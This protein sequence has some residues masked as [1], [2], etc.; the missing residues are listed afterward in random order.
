MKKSRRIFSVFP[1]PIFLFV[2]FVFVT[3]TSSS[4]EL[5]LEGGAGNISFDP[6]R[7][8]P[9]GGERFAPR[10]YPLALVSVSG[11]FN[12]TISYE[13]AWERDPV[14]RNRVTAGLALDFSFVR[15]EAGVLLSPFNTAEKV[16]S[17]GAAGGLTL[18]WPGVVFATVR[19]SSTLGSS[20]SLCGDHIQETGE[21][22]LGFWVPNVVCSLSFASSAFSRRFNELL[23]TRD[24][25]TRYQFSADVHAKNVPYT[26]LV[27]MGYQNLKRSYAP[28]GP[29][30]GV[31]ETDELTSVYLGL[32]GTWRVNANLRM[33]A[34][35]EMPVYSWGKAPMLAPNLN[36]VLF[37]VRAGVIWTLPGIR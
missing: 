31:T 28:A 23:I 22:V 3:G 13:A 34:G 24:E 27:N 25:R 19:G 20:L 4:I 12:D 7:D 30:L 10:P 2:L 16:L 11:A 33:L 26:V 1:L 36:T 9:M 29:A 8:R 15:I 35:V 37:T 14:L 32:E 21:I 5:R 17:P 6:G 18:E